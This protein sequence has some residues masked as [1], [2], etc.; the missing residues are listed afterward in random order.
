MTALLTAV[1]SRLFIQTR[2]AS[3]HPLD[4]AYASLQ[5]GR[6][7]DF[8]DLREYEHGDDVRDVDW[9]A[10]A[11]AGE[12]LIKRSRATRMHTVVFAVDTGHGM[13][14]LSPDERPKSELAV[15]AVGSLGLLATRHGDD[16]SVIHG[17]ASGVT[18]TPPR[19]S[20]AGL[21]HALRAIS[22]ATSLDSPASSRDTLLGSV[23]RTVQK[24][25][26]LVVVTD[27]QPIS[28]AHESLL[29]RLQV[30][31]DVL[32]VTVRDADPVLDHRVEIARRDVDSGWLVPEFLHGDAQVVADLAAER[33]EAGRRR[34]ATLDRLEVSHAEL[35]HAET[36]VPRILA[37]LARRSHVRS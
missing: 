5:R 18:R 33:A 6:S 22:A 36:A 15:L 21:E 3:S 2:L 17:D 35:S 31:H 26:I 11:R 12:L 34:A 13:A 32:W 19:R 28:P 23:A 4:G 27:E 10:T 30:Q 24:R 9:R 25:T 7:L 20:E 1:K 37:M 8:E 16:V 14:A 29:R